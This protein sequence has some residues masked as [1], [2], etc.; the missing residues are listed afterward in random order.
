LYVK[1]TS[2]GTLA[3]AG[4]QTTAGKPTTADEANTLGQNAMQ[5]IGSSPQ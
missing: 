1:A 4:M 3:T 2:S 5:Q